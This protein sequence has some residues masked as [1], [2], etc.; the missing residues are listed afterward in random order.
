MLVSTCHK[1]IS[2]FSYWVTIH[3][4]R[5]W[6]RRIAISS[7]IDPR[8]SCVK[9]NK[10]K[11]IWSTCSKLRANVK[12]YSKTKNIPASLL[13]YW[14]AYTCFF[15][16]LCFHGK[17]VSLQVCI[18]EQISKGKEKSILTKSHYPSLQHRCKN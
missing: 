16:G 2:T 13:Y 11:A 18:V 15:F 10:N 3:R 17:V 5:E 6:Y 14:Y 8:K 1:S 9:K 4:D 7:I 12:C